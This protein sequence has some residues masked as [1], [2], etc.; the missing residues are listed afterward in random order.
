[1]GAPFTHY[2]FG[3]FSF[4]A[5][6]IYVYY[7]V[8]RWNLWT[9]FTPEKN[10][11]IIFGICLSAIMVYL[12][13]YT[14]NGLGEYENVTLPLFDSIMIVGFIS[15]FVWLCSHV[16][17]TELVAYRKL[18]G[19]AIENCDKSYISHY[20]QYEFYDMESNFPILRSSSPHYLRT[21][22]PS[23]KEFDTIKLNKRDFEIETISIKINDSFT[24]A[25]SVNK[26][27]NFDN[28]DLPSDMVV[29]ISGRFLID[30]D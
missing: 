1:M 20:P 3:T 25:E 10:E 19:K 5:I 23:L 14:L 24:N 9:T 13:Y 17:A 28:I 8:Y 29:Q 21:N 6:V 11:K 7:L 22:F 12:V 18:R 15:G 16:A 30:L 4:W 26:L 2:A 27:S